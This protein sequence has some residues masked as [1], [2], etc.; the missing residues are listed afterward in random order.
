MLQCSSTDFVLRTDAVWLF[1]Q[2]KIDPS[3]L[4]YC[5]EVM[6]MLKAVRKVFVT[7]VDHATPTRLLTALPNMEV[8][9][10]IDHHLETP[11]VGCHNLVEAVGSCATLVA[12]TLLGAGHLV[13]PAAIATLLLGAIMVDTVCLDAEQGR[14]SDKD[15]AMAEALGDISGISAAH[16][17]ANLSKARFA[18]CGLSVDQLLRKDL[19]CCKAGGQCLGFSSVPC[20]VD[21]L[22]EREGVEEG[23][24]TL[25]CSLGLSALV[26]LGVKM[27]TGSITRQI[28]VY[29]PQGSDLADA[30]AGVLESDPDLDCRHLPAKVCILLGQGNTRRSRKHILPTVVTFISSL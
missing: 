26:V 8:V 24:H 22:L 19:K 12:E 30:V 2:L 17:Y 13:M 1:E 25:C 5:N 20:L 15:R 29:Q 18:V 16:L 4:L 21:E 11:L 6:G 23:M 28:A 7:M 14:V 3:Q 10:V 27:E 9:Q